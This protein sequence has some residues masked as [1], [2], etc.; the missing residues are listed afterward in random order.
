VLLRAHGVRT[1]D[2]GDAA[3]SEGRGIA[4]IASEIA[5]I[6]EKG[7][8][9]SEGRGGIAEGAC[10]GGLTQMASAVVEAAP[11]TVAPSLLWLTGQQVD[12]ALLMKAD[13]C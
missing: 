12:A 8:K 9:G 2:D 6:G 11:V 1:L 7:E 13:D 10:G 5:E 4:E 3:G